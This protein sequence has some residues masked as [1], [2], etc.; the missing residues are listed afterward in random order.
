MSEYVIKAYEASDYEKVREFLSGVTTLEQIEDDLFANSIIIESAAGVVGMI[1]YEEFRGRAL[2][3][4]F[5]FDKD[6]EEEHLITMYDQFFQRLRAKGL[7]Q[8]FVI[9]HHEMIIELFTN[10][11]FEAFDKR[12]FFLTESNIEHTKYKDATV[13]FYTLD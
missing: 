8:I 1:S 12:E 3:R 5:I 4:Y 7:K 9:V 2:I 6:V 11:G 13:M 10:L